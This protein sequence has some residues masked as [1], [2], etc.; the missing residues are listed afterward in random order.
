MGNRDRSYSRGGERRRRRSKSRANRR[1]ISEDKAVQRFLA[2]RRKDREEGWEDSRG[3]KA[4]RGRRDRRGGGGGAAA[5]ARDTRNPSPTRAATGNDWDCAACGESNWPTRTKCRHCKCGRTGLRLWPKTAAPG[6]QPPLPPRKAAGTAT[7]AAAA[8]AGA[9][10]G[11]PAEEGGRAKEGPQIPTRREAAATRATEAAK[12][13]KLD[14][15]LAALGEGEEDEAAREALQQARRHTAERMAASKPLGQRLDQGKRR[16]MKANLALAAAEAAVLK[17]QAIAEAALTEQHAARHELEDLE[18]QLA[19]LQ[20]TQAPPEAA[21]RAATFA[22]KVRQWAAAEGVQLP[23]EVQ[24]AA[25]E[26]EEALAP[27][28]EAARPEPS[29]GSDP[30]DMNDVLSPEDDPASDPL[31]VATLATPLAR[32]RSSDADLPPATRRRSAPPAPA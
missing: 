10:P 22:D 4:G 1:S 14:A 16:A 30:T 21:T 17:A 13:A 8:G 11:Q 27:T 6:A 5:T 25:D 29:V 18:R 20:G 12:L 3:G 31:S 9:P 32:V 26:L 28:R 24:A 19:E 2:T 7:T 23:D 15:A